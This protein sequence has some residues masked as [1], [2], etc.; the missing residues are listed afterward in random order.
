MTARRFRERLLTVGIAA[1]LA[2]LMMGAGRRVP[3]PIA[4][5]NGGGPRG[6]SGSLDPSFAGDGATWAY[7]PWYNGGP[8]VQSVAEAVAVDAA[9]KII[10]AIDGTTDSGSQ[11]G[12]AIVRYNS[13]GTLDMTF[14]SNGLAL[15]GPGE[16]SAMAIQPDGRIVVAG[17]GFSVARFMADGS[18]DASFGSGGQVSTLVRGLSYDLALQEDGRI[19]LGGYV[20][21]VQGGG[22]FI[23]LVRYNSDGSLDTSFGSS[24][25][26]LSDLQGQARAVTVQPDGRI[27][28]AGF[29]F[30]V[31]RFNADGT[32]DTGFGSEGQISLPFGDYGWDSQAQDILVQP[33][34]KIVVAGGAWTTYDFAIARLN[35]DGSLDSGFGHDGMV[36]TD[37]NGGF[38][39]I[40]ALV[41]QPD[42]KLV[43]AGYGGPSHRLPDDDHF[44]LARYQPDGALDRTFGKGGKAMAEIDGPVYADFA[45]ALA[46]QPDGRLVAAGYIKICTGG[47]EKSGYALARF[48]P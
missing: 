39:S 14:G 32:I 46:L 16:V 38:D 41:L 37:F 36:T 42:G 1:G 11:R 15:A 8:F 18:P 3:D 34:D 21:P 9:G 45:R 12:I 22:G 40:M 31:V 29:S 25:V 2:V 44:A 20:E 13:D 23:A 4:G 24:G 47:C 17:S 26:V 27:L 30:Q 43:A 5:R 35:P 7:V 19:V 33:D 48:L 10:V 6:H 28:T